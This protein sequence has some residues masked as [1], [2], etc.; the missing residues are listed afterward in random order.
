MYINIKNKKESIV[1]IAGN[2]AFLNINRNDIPLLP[3]LFT[4]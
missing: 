3:I 1:I 4:P 2:G